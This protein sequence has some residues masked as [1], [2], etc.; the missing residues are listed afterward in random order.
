M[1]MERRDRLV[2]HILETQPVLTAFVRRRSHDLGEGSW[3]LLSYS[4]QRGFETLWDSASADQSELLLRPLLVL[5][6]QSVELAIK[7]AIIDIAG[8]ILARPGH[9]LTKLFDQLLAAR[10]ELG[11]DDND[12]YTEQVKGL[13]GEVQAVDPYADRFR[14]PASK[15]GTPFAGIDVEYDALFQAYW[16]ITVWCEGAALEVEEARSTP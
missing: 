4:F 3:D 1:S 12:E 16:M 6:R 8:T 13:I 15:D 2:E 11:Y 14:Y 10:R 9:N 7:A 5:W